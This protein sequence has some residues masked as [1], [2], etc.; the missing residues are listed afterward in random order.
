MT[1]ETLLPIMTAAV[2][3]SAVSLLT[4]AYF[5]YRVRR[6]VQELAEKIRN[7]LPRAAAFFEQADNTLQQTR[8]QLAAVAAKANKVLDQAQ[9]Q[10]V[11]VD[12]VLT[13]VSARTKSQMERI[14]LVLDDT[15]GRVH[16]TVIT[17]NNGILRPLREINGLAAGLKVGLGQLLRRR[18][19]PVDRATADEEMFI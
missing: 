14:E 12:G 9:T 16:Q 13:D 5:A 2:V 6:Q 19:S 11:V 18:R 10:L 4:Q 17:L 7:E 3:L 8:E 15:V 1:A